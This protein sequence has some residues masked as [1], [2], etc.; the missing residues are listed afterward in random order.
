[1]KESEPLLWNFNLLKKELKHIQDEQIYGSLPDF[2]GEKADYMTKYSDSGTY[3]RGRV[4]YSLDFE[5]KKEAKTRTVRLKYK[6]PHNPRPNPPVRIYILRVDLF[7]DFELPNAC[8]LTSSHVFVTWSPYQL[9]FQ[10]GKI[11]NN[12]WVWN[13]VFPDLKITHQQPSTKSMI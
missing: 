11:V 4:W 3:Y 2:K 10:K 7:D 1:M 8:T 6:L 9:M 13:Y 5:E 12:I